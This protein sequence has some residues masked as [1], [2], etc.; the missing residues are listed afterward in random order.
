MRSLFLAA[1]SA[2]SLSSPA[3]AIE[4]RYEAARRAGLE[5]AINSSPFIGKEVETLCFAI[6]ADIQAVTCSVLNDY[7]EESGQ[8]VYFLERID[9]KSGADLVSECGNG[10]L[11]SGTVRPS[12]RLYVKSTVDENGNRY[13][14]KFEQ[15]EVRE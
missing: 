10:Q 7:D 6:K 1:I 9:P 8:V 15:A 3:I 4:G 14:L 11:P 13:A 12:C 2:V 5:L